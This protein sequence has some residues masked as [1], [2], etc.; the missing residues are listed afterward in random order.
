M[1]DMTIR[2]KEGWKITPT[3]NDVSCGTFF[4]NNYVGSQP[5]TV[6]DKITIETI[7]ITNSFD[8]NTFISIEPE[9]DSGKGYACIGEFKADSFNFEGNTH[10]YQLCVLSEGSKKYGGT[11]SFMLSSKAPFKKGTVSF[12]ASDDAKL[13]EVKSILSQI[14]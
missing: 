2:G 4:F 5:C 11:D 10:Q 8:P 7:K 6:N 13:S 14:Q 3:K 12:V 9:Y 1:F